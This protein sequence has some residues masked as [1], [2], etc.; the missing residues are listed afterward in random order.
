MKLKHKK[1]L[2]GGI[3]LKKG[4]FLSTVLSQHAA[5]V[6]GMSR[7]VCNFEKEGEFQSCVRVNSYCTTTVK[8]SSKKIDPSG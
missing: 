3:I 7:C 1:D 6:S 4:L 8:T 5:Y 2:K